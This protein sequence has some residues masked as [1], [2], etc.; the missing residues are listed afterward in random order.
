M[1]SDKR[2]I[3]AKIIN[4]TDIYSDE[5]IR[6][7]QYKILKNDIKQILE[8]NRIDVVHSHLPNAALLLA[9]LD[10]I[11]VPA[12]HTMHGD[13]DLISSNIKISPYMIPF[14]KL[15]ARRYKNALGKMDKVTAVSNF[16]TS[17]IEKWEIKLK[18]KTIVI[19]NGINL[20]DFKNSLMLTK[21]LEGKF[22]LLYPGGEKRLKGG[23]LLILA[24]AKLRNNISGFHLYIAGNVSNNDI[25]RQ[26][27]MNLGLES[28]IT[29]VGILPKEEYRRLLNSVDILVMPSRMEAFGI[30]YIEAMALGK[31]VIASNTGGIPEVVQDGRN[32]ILV[33]LDSEQIA[34]AIS[35]LYQHA[36]I[37]EEMGRN[38]LHDVTKFDWN[39]ITD[40][41]I[42]L[43]KKMLKEK[44]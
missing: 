25:L 36:D 44:I 14:I 6:Y 3:F 27:V 37:R 32:G 5:L 18:S 24:L 21:E 9:N 19:Y 39:I 40:Q 34:K 11:K 17:S 23:D 35:Y 41:Y 22:N 42:C 2:N 4:L 29:F 38:N 16:V 7:R 28:N 13:W 43:Y 20:T 1:Y 8:D 12:I 15:K 26:M 10:I 31:P 30:A 33:E